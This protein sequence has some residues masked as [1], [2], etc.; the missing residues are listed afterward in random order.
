MLK[1]KKSQGA[2]YLAGTGRKLAV[3]LGLGKAENSLEV[4]LF[5]LVTDGEA[6]KT[7]ISESYNAL[8]TK[9]WL[10]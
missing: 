6:V 10:C 3:T 1:I 8:L 4:L 2:A 5:N 7:K 9:W